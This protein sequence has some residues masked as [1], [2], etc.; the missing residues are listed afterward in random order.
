MAQELERWRFALE[1]RGMKISR[2]KTEYLCVNKQEAGRPPLKL[3]GEDV[4]EVDEFKY[5]GSTIQGNGDC[6]REL[7]KRIQAGWNGWRKMTGI[8]CDKRAPVKIK[9]MI[10]RMVVRPVMMYGLETAAMTRRQE[11]QLEVAEMRMLRFSLGVTR[12][13]KIRNEFIR[14]TLKVDR[15]GQKVRQSRLRWYGHVK[16]RDEDYVGR[17]VLEMPLPGK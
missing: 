5:L 16:R 9:G 8:L 17:K 13:D 3:Q 7:K 1:R 6:D 4:P 15:I 12:K 10:L 11:K 14:G 2:K